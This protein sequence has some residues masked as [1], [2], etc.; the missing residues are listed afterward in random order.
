MVDMVN[1]KTLRGAGNQ[2]VHPNIL[3]LAVPCRV[4]C[5][6][7]LDGIPFV[8]AQPVVVVGI[9]DSELALC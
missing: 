3:A 6:R 2:P 4:V 5:F 7:S 8:L 9:D 1:E